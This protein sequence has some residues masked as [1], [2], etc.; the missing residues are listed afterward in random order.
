MRWKSGPMVKA[1]RWTNEKRLAVY[2]IIVTFA[3]GVVVTQDSYIEAPPREVVVLPYVPPLCR[4]IMETK[5]ADGWTR[6]SFESAGR[7]ARFE[8][9]RANERAWTVQPLVFVSR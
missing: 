5:P 9:G 1:R 7:V 6:L 8:C 3:L 2:A 4:E